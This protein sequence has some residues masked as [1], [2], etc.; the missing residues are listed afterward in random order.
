MNFDKSIKIPYHLAIILD[1]NGRWA[2]SKGLVRTLGHK[3]GAQ[4]LI[5]IIDASYEM[6]VK[7]LSIF[8]FSTENWKRS[9]KEIEFLFSLP[10]V[11]FKKYE[12]ILIKKDIKVI[13]SGDINALPYNT[14]K[15]LNEIK[16][17]TRHC[18]KFILNVCINYG[19]QDEILNVIKQIALK[20]KKGDLDVSSISKDVIQQHLYTKNLPAVDLLIRT[21]NEKRISNF[22]LWQ[23]AYSE[24]YF[25]KKYWPDFNKNDLIEAFI[26]YS[27]RDR[28]YGG[29]N[30]EN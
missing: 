19:G 4:T 12:S 26:D 1:G 24:I 5:N 7:I 28:R 10:K 14:F 17:K 29:I 22:M 6:N 15:V 3:K 20:V 13:F 2:T 18:S 30:Y 16:S 25:S 9:E 8:C 11:Y 27:K 23:I 21:S